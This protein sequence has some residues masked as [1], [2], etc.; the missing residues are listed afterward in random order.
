MKKQV[1]IYESL[2]YSSGRFTMRAGR[3]PGKGYS[4]PILMFGPSKIQ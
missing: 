4:A 1:R 3:L 2:T